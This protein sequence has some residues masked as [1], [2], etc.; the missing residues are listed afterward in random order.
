VATLIDHQSRAHARLSGSVASIFTK[1]TAAPSLWEGRIRKATAFTREGTAAHELSDAILTGGAVPTTTITVE[2][3]AIE[4]TDEMR[5]AVN[6][7]VAYI[8]VLRESADWHAIEQRFTMDLLWHPNEAP[9]PMFGSADYVGVSGPV[10]DVADLKFGKGVPVSAENN[11]QL[12]FYATGVWLWLLE[13]RSDL[14]SKIERVRLHIVQPRI[15]TVP[16]TAEITLL[17]LLMWAE[18]ILK[19]SVDDITAGNTSFKAGAHCGFCLGKGVCPELAA[20]AMKA[21][22]NVFPPAPP[23]TIS[24]DEIGEALTRAELVSMWL[25]GVRAE[26]ETRIRHGKKVPGFKMVEKKGYRQWTNAND[27]LGF[28]AEE[29]QTQPTMFQSEPELLSPAQVEKKLKAMGEDPAILSPYITAPTTG[30]TLVPETDKRPPATNITPSEV[31]GV[32]EGE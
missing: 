27:V 24:D 29:F 25:N 28:L 5:V 18:E 2:G 17:D 30:L 12:L 22:K 4:V 32:V 16:S 31:F 11:A 10:L 15:S 6:D 1:C 23:Q 3:E 21:A 14:A 9:E 7:Y 8:N 20:E 13:N 19:K 26:V